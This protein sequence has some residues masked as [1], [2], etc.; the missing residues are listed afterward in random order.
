MDDLNLRYREIISYEPAG[1]LVMTHEESMETAIPEYCPDLTRIVDT[2]GQIWVREKS[3]TDGKMSVSGSIHVTVLYTS[4]ESAGLRSL[5]VSLPF[6]CRAEDKRA[7]QTV[8]VDGKL[9]L[10]E[11]KMLGARKLYIRAL[12]EFRVRGYRR[13][14]HHLCTGVQEDEGLQ[15]LRRQT[16][17]P[18][19]TN[20]WE[21]DINFAQEIAPETGEEQT[22]DLLMDRVF[23]QLNS[24]QHFGNK[25]VIKGEAIMSMLCRAEDQ[26]LNSRQV[27]LPFSQIIDGEDLPEEATFSCIA[28]MAEHEIHPVRTE[29]GSG[30]GVTMRITLEIR[31]YEQLAVDYV[32]DL[33]STRREVTAKLADIAFS[34]AAVPEDIRRDCDQRLDGAGS[35]A[36]LT[37]TKVSQPEVTALEGGR[38][39]LRG[40]LRMKILYLDDTGTPVTAE[41]SAEVGAELGQMPSSV[42]VRTGPESWQRTGNGFEVRV[43]VLFSLQRSDQKELC[44]VT[45]AQQGGEIDHSAA[46]SLILRRLQEGESL[47]DVAKQCQTEEAIILSAN[48]LGNGAEATD[49]RLLLIPRMR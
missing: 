36:Y 31:T 19:L 24:C 47:W 35:F 42:R 14:Q 30:L 23:L 16:V 11:V 15:I 43:P 2:A 22:A 48:E 29:S 37:D 49:H 21:R 10:L 26:T 18:L 25:L 41:R 9:L 27:T 12:P 32:A 4:E 20:I 13:V 28:R 44:A 38:P 17:L 39:A 6:T 34:T 33:Y 45:A 46:P 5:T 3:L 40:T 7:C 1:D 8:S